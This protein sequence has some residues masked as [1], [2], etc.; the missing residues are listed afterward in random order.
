MGPFWFKVTGFRHKRKNLDGCFDHAL[1]C[2]DLIQNNNTIR[3]LAHEET[4]V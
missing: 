4:S 1:S 2:T 3:N